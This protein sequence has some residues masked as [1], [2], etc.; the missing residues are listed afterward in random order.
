MKK[1]L[2]RLVRLCSFF[3]GS[4]S[5]DSKAITEK[6][7]SQISAEAQWRLGIMYEF[8]RGVPLDRAEAAKWYRMAAEQGFVKAQH[9]LGVL[10]NLGH[11]VPR[12]RAEA[13]KWFRKAAEQGHAEAQYSLGLMYSTGGVP[14]DYVQAY[15][16]LNLAAAQGIKPAQEFRD[17]LAKLMTPSQI[18]EAQRQA[19]EWRPKSPDK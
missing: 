14:Q 13:A 18:A 10:Y 3:P 16:W 8:G 2:R 5:D 11:N 12:D 6:L 4:S 1:I 7:L 17:I 19:R 9:T 15:M